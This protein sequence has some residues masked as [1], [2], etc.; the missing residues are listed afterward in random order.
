MARNPYSGLLIAVVALGGCG[1]GETA[2]TAAI[3]G[4]S[5]AQ[6]ATQARRVQDQV[7][8]RVGE[9]LQQSTARLQALDAARP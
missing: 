1:L 9:T 6:Q 3:A 5:A 2:A 7:Q 4:G 8:Q